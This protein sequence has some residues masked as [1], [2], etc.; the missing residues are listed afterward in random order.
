MIVTGMLVSAETHEI[1]RTYP[2]ENDR[3][4]GPP[5]D[6]SGWFLV[7]VTPTVVTWARRRDCNLVEEAIDKERAEFRSTLK[8]LVDFYGRQLV[9]LGYV[10]EQ[11]VK[12]G[13]PT[14]SNVRPIIRDYEARFSQHLDALREHTFPPSDNWKRRHA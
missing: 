10:V 14:N 8:S 5:N 11:Q 3:A 12:N 6:R 9:E 4:L 7:D 2:D 1:A 13:T